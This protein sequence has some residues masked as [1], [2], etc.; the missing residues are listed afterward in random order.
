MA[1]TTAAPA[2]TRARSVN[3]ANPLALLHR[4]LAVR[5]GKGP[6]G[7]GELTISGGSGGEGGGTWRVGGEHNHHD[8]A[9]GGRGVRRGRRVDGAV[10]ANEA[11]VGEGNA[12]LRGR[13]RRSGRAIVARRQGEGG[14]PDHL[15]GVREGGLAGST[16]H[17]RERG[18]HGRSRSPGGRT[19]KRQATLRGLISSRDI[20]IIT[21]ISILFT[22]FLKV[23]C[24]ISGFSSSD[25]VTTRK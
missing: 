6:E 2:A 14:S 18:A 20:I 5:Q 12:R 13:G 22:L 19:P 23:V 16:T 10:G 17:N 15:V 4:W 1:D 9:W 11:G 21:S 7:G 24:F 8:S 25:T 3:P